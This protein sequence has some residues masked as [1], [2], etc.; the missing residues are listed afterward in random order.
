MSMGI[1]CITNS[2]NGKSYIGK[3]NDIDRRR[4][5]HFSA[6]GNDEHDNEEMQRDYNKYGNDCFEFS[7]LE[8][9]EDENKLDY[10]EDYYIKKFDSLLNGYNRCRGNIKSVLSTDSFSRKPTLEKITKDNLYFSLQDLIR[11]HNKVFNESLKLSDFLDIYKR[12]DSKF[13]IC[14]SNGTRLYL[15]DSDVEKYISK[16][17]IFTSNLYVSDE[18]LE[19]TD[20]T[21]D[22]ISD[23]FD[24]WNMYIR[25]RTKEL[26]LNNNSVECKIEL[27]IAKKFVDL[28][29][30]VPISM[31]EKMENFMDY[32]L[33]AIMYF[34][35]DLDIDDEKSTI[36]TIN[37]KGLELTI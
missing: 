25:K 19:E 22:K 12:N 34:L 26:L 15:E 31:L 14:T 6:L 27:K 16:Y 2:A 21:E 17:I 8:T 4:T 29:E 10:I 35:N 30:N 36:E 3:S 33:Q 9:V 20:K 5:Q 7:V 28:L 23:L 37:H 18:V 24:E 1:Y 11:L 13:Y 32:E